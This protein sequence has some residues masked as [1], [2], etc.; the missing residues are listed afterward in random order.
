MIIKDTTLWKF[1][2]HVL[3]FT[4]IDNNGLEG[5]EH[6][7]DYLTGVPGRWI[8]TTDAASRHIL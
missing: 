5:L 8:K 1:C 4:N 7:D 2:S 6:I 3:G